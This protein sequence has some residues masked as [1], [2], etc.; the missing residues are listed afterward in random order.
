[1]RRLEL[2]SKATVIEGP[3]ARPIRR[4]HFG[5]FVVGSR[6]ECENHLVTVT[7][8]TPKTIVL[9]PLGVRK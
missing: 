3:N 8:I 1:M 7:K 6:V 5:P 4:A 9:K 2:P